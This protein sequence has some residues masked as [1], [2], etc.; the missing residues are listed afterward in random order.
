MTHIKNTKRFKELSSE[1]K[2]KEDYDNQLREEAQGEL[3]QEDC[4]FSRLLDIENEL[5]SLG[6]SLVY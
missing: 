5:N 4:D 3:E 1:I 6:D 2:A